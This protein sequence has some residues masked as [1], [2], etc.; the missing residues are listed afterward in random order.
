MVAGQAHILTVGSSILSPA[1]VIGS[2]F[3]G[4]V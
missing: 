1:I 4:H 2:C 3:P